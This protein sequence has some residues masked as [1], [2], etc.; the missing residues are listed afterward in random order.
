MNQETLKIGHPFSQLA[1]CVF[2]CR[3]EKLPYVSGKEL[4]SRVCVSTEELVS[5]VQYI[6]QYCD[7]DCSDLYRHIGVEYPMDMD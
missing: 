2:T 6:L 1:Y 7:Q 4:V 3:V 5:T